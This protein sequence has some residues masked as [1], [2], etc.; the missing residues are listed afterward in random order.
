MARRVAI[1]CDECRRKLGGDETFNRHHYVA[2]DR[3]KCYSDDELKARGMYRDR[4]GTWHR[5]TNPAQGVLSL[6]VGAQANGTPTGNRVGS[7]HPRALARAT[8]PATS[9]KAA[10]AIAP[11]TG[12][13]KRVILEAFV[14]AGEEG[15]TAF[16]AAERVGIEP[17]QVSKRVSDLRKDGLIIQVGERT[18]ANGRDR[19]VY[20]AEVS[21]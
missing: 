20:R 5:G 16:E 21:V 12:T 6:S 8:D 9:H 18:G 2:G 7:E 13:L 17:W 11:R 4:F 1:T 3:W 19:N 14:T 15:L 10:A